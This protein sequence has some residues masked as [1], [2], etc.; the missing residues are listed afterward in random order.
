[1]GYFQHDRNQNYFFANNYFS[2]LIKKDICERILIGKYDTIKCKEEYIKSIDGPKIN[3]IFGDWAMSLPINELIN[4]NKKTN[5]YEFIFYN[6]K[7]FDHWSLGRPLVRF[8]HMVYD[9][10]N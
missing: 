4:L 6:K 7:N 3:L 9:Y 1:M 10:Q 5:N 2:E 8:F